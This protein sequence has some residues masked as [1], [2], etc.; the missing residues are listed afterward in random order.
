MKHKKIL[1]LISAFVVVL[2]GVCLGWR[3]DIQKQVASI[4]DYENQLKEYELSAQD[5]QAQLEKLQSENQELQEENSSILAELESQTL[6]WQELKNE[7]GHCYM[8]G[9]EEQF[10][11][12]A[13]G[14]QYMTAENVPVRRMPSDNEMFYSPNELSYYM[15]TPIAAV[16]NYVDDE[17]THWVFVKFLTIGDAADNQGW[18]KFSELIEYT[19][20]T[21]SLLKG[22]FVLSEDA[23]DIRTGN[24]VDMY[25]R[26]SEVN[27]E[28]KEGYVYVITD[29]GISAN[30]DEKYLIYPEVEYNAEKGKREAAQA[31]FDDVYMNYLEIAQLLIGSVTTTRDEVKDEKGF[32]YLYVKEE[33]YDDVADIEALMKSVFT[34]SYIEQNLDWVLQGDGPLYKEINGKLCIRMADAP[35]PGTPREISEILVF[36]ENDITFIVEDE[37]NKKKISL[38][39]KADSW[40][41]DMMEYLEK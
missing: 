10:I 31:I 8:G 24:P 38:V 30:V 35:E 29:G 6:E 36:E 21:K 11:K 4:V 1:I 23:V 39:K 2:I 12:E 15:V 25:L 19:E 32:T 13:Y 22:P 3:N 33:A 20:D 41:I 27:A 40:L 5:A 16:V 28:F 14:G 26:G 37:Y 17:V 9:C 34:T 18:V 7:I